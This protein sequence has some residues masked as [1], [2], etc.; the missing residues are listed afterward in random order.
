M[1][2]KA[3]LYIVF[4]LLSSA[5]LFSAGNISWRTYFGGSGEDIITGMEELYGNIYVTGYTNSP[6][7]FNKGYNSTPYSNYGY[8]AFVAKFDRDGKLVWSTYV[9]STGDDKATS[10]AID[11][12]TH[13]IIIAGSTKST[14]GMSYSSNVYQGSC[15]GQT[16][17]FIAV[18]DDNGKKLWATYFGGYNNDIISSIS[19]SDDSQIAFCGSTSSYANIAKGGNESDKSFDGATDAFAGAFDINGNLRW[20]S[21]FGGSAAD[22][23][24]GV[25]FVD[26]EVIITGKTSSQSHV[27]DLISYPVPYQSSYGGGSSDA[28]IA[29]FDSNGKLEWSTYFGGPN[30]DEALSIGAYYSSGIFICGKTNSDSGIASGGVLNSELAGGWDGFVAKF[31]T[32]GQFEWSGYFGGPGDE[33]IISAKTDYFGNYVCAG[34]TNSA[35]GIAYY[36]PIQDTLAGGMDGFLFEV[37]ESGGMMYG[38]YF[39]GSGDD[40]ATAAIFSND[41][42]IY[43]GGYTKDAADFATPNCN[44]DTFGGGSYDCYISKCNAQS[45]T[46]SN[47]S[48]YKIC[49]GDS[50]EISYKTTGSFPTGSKLILELSNDLGSFSNPLR[51]DTFN[52]QSSDT[53]KA[54]IPDNVLYG[55]N[56][57]LRFSTNYGFISQD[58]GLGIT[59]YTKPVSNIFGDRVICDTSKAYYYYASFDKNLSYKWEVSHGTIVWT[60]NRDSVAVVWN[61]DASA[62]LELE[63]ENDQCS[64]ESILKPTIE[65]FAV[66]S[67]LAPDNICAGVGVNFSTFA[68]HTEYS[69]IIEN[70]DNHSDT[71]QKNISVIWNT[72]GN[73]LI[74]VVY[75][76]GACSD[77]AS[78]VIVVNSLPLLS[79][80]GADT[81]CALAANNKYSIEHYDGAIV[82]WFIT[83]GNII[84]ANDKDTVEVNWYNIGP[85]SLKCYYAVGECSDTTY[86]NTTIQVPPINNIIGPDFICPNT[87]VAYTVQYETPKSCNWTAINGTITSENG[88][89]DVTVVWNT[90]ASS[91]ELRLELSSNLC[92]V[93]SAKNVTLIT[94]EDLEILGANVTCPDCE[95]EYSVP[96][97]RNAIY[98]W[99]I[100]GGSIISGSGK[101]K[102]NV[103]WNGNNQGEIKLKLI[104]Q[105]GDCAYEK[106]FSVNIPSGNSIYG[107]DTVCRQN[108]YYYNCSLSPDKVLN[109]YVQ[110]G[111]KYS[112]ISNS[113]IYVEW[114]NAGQNKLICEYLS[115]DSETDSLILDVW[116]ND[117]PEI[118]MDFDS[119]LCVSDNP[120]PLDFALPAG[121]AYFLDGIE[122]LFA[123]TPSELSLGKHTLVYS[124]RND[125]GCDI[126][127]QKDFIVSPLLE[128][129]HLNYN[130]PDLEASTSENDIVWYYN[131][132]EITPAKGKTFTPD[133]SGDYSIKVKNM[134]GCESGSSNTVNIDLD[135]A[136]HIT[137]NHEVQLTDSYC[138]DPG[139]GVLNIKNSGIGKLELK[140]IELSDQVPGFRISYD[141]TVKYLAAGE[142]IDVQL[143]YLPEMLGL[144][145]SDLYISTDD[146]LVPV[147]TTVVKTNAFVPELSSSVNEISKEGLEI[148]KK[149]FDTILVRNSGNATTKLDISTSD[150]KVEIFEAPTQIEVGEEYRIIISFMP[151]KEG[152]ITVD[153]NIRDDCGKILQVPISYGIKAI[154][155]YTVVV[156]SASANS[157]DTVIINISL[158]N[159]Q[160]MVASGITQLHAEF[161]SNASVLYPVNQEDRGVISNNTRTIPIDMDL[162]SQTSRSIMFI[163]TLGNDSVSALQVANIHDDLGYSSYITVDGEFRLNDLCN[164]GG[165]RLINLSDAIQF[166]ISP[167]PASDQLIIETKLIESGYST[168]KIYNSFGEV[169]ETV[170]DGFWEK[171]DYLLPVDLRA[172]GSGK[173]FVILITPTRIKSASLEILK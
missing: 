131:G 94:P 166:T 121:G 114:N 147:R 153:L 82:K 9:G 48:T 164:S 116:V 123:I 1:K 117:S 106:T 14:Y 50:I 54:K 29:G 161:K 78:K 113:E 91:A 12:S 104:L 108:R 69:W 53:C 44:Q 142:S 5:S 124:Y 13:K 127:K 37:T 170:M 15:A 72:P 173:Y 2:I 67:I 172:L 119:Y 24:M 30:D 157:G 36:D 112:G 39:G 26:N 171:G 28:F 74:K 136:P 52:F 42:T 77:T 159:A 115:D 95:N 92:T 22:S 46:F 49:A 130:P 97:Y 110:S 60:N 163:A 132:I 76:N 149:N 165:T 66:D 62:T 155:E 118:T 27:A 68:Y 152:K 10:I 8:D 144:I 11:R 154:P 80:K 83:G 79:I 168:V 16:D 61:N 151:D 59:I 47:I 103:R 33:A 167:N 105:G 7:T 129:P 139:R 88:K 141:S 81:V 63:V 137:C 4:L 35:S 145:S 3:A 6:N 148:N 64:G 169:A 20:A 32:E 18:F 43:F 158:P 156:G 133:K 107:L 23:A 73:Y 126:L 102:V 55:T 17:G 128:T 58:N 65:N 162:G 21:Y 19:V 134:A 51:L 86:F 109:W 31:K 56:Y 138:T 84:G 122:Q 25:A 125:A 120:I 140:K 93:F 87:P 90:D 160:S 71:A 98:E 101:N 38:T 111:V 57:R 135:D 85:G 146:N 75:G 40:Y 150:P 70:A 41:G 100:K 45:L 99:S 34:Y 89:K 143:Q 96:Y